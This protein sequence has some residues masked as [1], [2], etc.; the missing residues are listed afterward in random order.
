M[1]G[2]KNDLKDDSR[3]FELNDRKAGTASNLNGRQWEEPFEGEDEGS[4]K[5]LHPSI[6]SKLCTL[7]TGSICREDEKYFSNLHKSK[8]YDN[9]EKS[10]FGFTHVKGFFNI[11][12]SNV[13][14]KQLNE[15]IWRPLN[16]S[17]RGNIIWDLPA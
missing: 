2:K 8:W 1:V 7:L 5:W 13:S 9:Q 14:S 17:R 3:I 10:Q 15:Q 16:N 4:C 12:P 11:Y 6:Q